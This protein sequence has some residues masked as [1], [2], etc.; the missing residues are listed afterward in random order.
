MILIFSLPKKKKKELDV[1]IHLNFFQTTTANE[2]GNFLLHFFPVRKSS[3]ILEQSARARNARRF[4]IPNFTIPGSGN[5]AEERLAVGS[6]CLPP[7]RRRARTSKILLQ[8]VLNRE[9]WIF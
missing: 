4:H 3:R 9:K 8:A 6:C 2:K 1:K 5:G 7:V